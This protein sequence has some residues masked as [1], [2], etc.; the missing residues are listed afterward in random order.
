MRATG[1]GR[2]GKGH[3]ETAEAVRGFEDYLARQTDAKLP[4]EEK[5]LEALARRYKAEEA[6]GGDPPTTSVKTLQNWSEWHNWQD[7]VTAHVRET[8]ALVLKTMKSDSAGRIIRRLKTANKLIESIDTQVTH[9]VPADPR[10]FAKLVELEA[11]L[12]GEPLEDVHKHKIGQD[13]DAD[14]LTVILER[15]APK[16]IAEELG[17]GRFAGDTGGGARRDVAPSGGEAPAGEGEA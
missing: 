6:A 13:P 17:N 10:E 15:F 12:F 7:R 14:P 16:D 9:G 2:N 4:K 1:D 3:K 11:K 5:S 8:N